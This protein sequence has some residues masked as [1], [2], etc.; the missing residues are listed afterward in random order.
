MATYIRLAEDI[1]EK[2][3]AAARKHRTSDFELTDQTA[4]GMFPKR[5][6]GRIGLPTT[7]WATF[8]GTIT[9]KQNSPLT[10]N[11]LSELDFVKALDRRLGEVVGHET[12]DRCQ[13][14]EVAF[15]LTVAHRGRRTSTTGY[16]TIKG[17]VTIST[18]H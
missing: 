5:G 14:V 1:L 15:M 9:L 6:G 3:A 11:P 18:A 7:H 4:S 12:H 17:T 8:N 13:D 2:I 16:V 10:V